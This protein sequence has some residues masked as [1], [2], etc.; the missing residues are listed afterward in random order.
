MF[1]KM[2][3]VI[4]K[5]YANSCEVPQGSVENP[6]LILIWVGFLGIRFEVG[7]GGEE[8]WVYYSPP[9]LKVVRIM[10]ESTHPCV[11]SENMPFSVKALL[12][13]LMAVLFAKNQR[14]LAKMYLYSKAIVRELC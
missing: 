9:C 5:I 2:F 7:V 14:F 3:Q 4:L 1:Q 10:L 8:G 13:L 11:V 6:I 12:I